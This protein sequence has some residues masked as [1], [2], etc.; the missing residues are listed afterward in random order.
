M[1]R[2]FRWTLEADFPSGKL[3][4]QFVKVSARPNIEIEEVNYL[5]EKQLKP[6]G[7]TWQTITTTIFDVNSE[8]PKIL[9]LWEIIKAVYDFT[10]QDKVKERT[11]EE[12]AK[13]AGT[14]KLQL[15]C[16]KYEYQPPPKPVEPVPPREPGNV[17]GI[18][19]IGDFYG[20]RT[21]VGWDTLEEW[22][23]KNAWPTSINFGELDYSSSDTCEIGITWRYSDVIYKNMCKPWQPPEPAVQ[24]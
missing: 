4:P 14:L 21:F 1:S 24:P 12:I 17:M 19:R 13:V 16:P 20:D 11:P 7:G 10:D 6:E 5:Q 8:D 2:K 9:P 3:E 18:G 22:T 23:L 15:L